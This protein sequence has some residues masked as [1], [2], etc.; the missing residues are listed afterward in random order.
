[1]VK[2]HARGALL[3]Q[4]MVAFCE[5]LDSDVAVYLS[6]AGARTEGRGGCPALQ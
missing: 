4:V 1:M 5:A 2:T 3:L 6:D